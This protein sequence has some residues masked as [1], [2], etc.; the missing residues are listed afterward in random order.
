MDYTKLIT[1]E[2]PDYTYMASQWQKFRDVMEGGPAFI[3]KYLV[4]FSSRET[5]PEFAERKAI[6]Y[7]AA[8][9]KSNLFKI[10]NAMFQRFSDIKRSGGSASYQNAVTGLNFGVN[11]AGLSMNTFVA[12]YLVEEL[13]VM[14]RVG[15]YV[16]KDPLHDSTTLAD[17]KGSSPYLYPYSTE[18]I[19]SW[20]VNEKNELTAVLLVDAVDDIEL[21]SGLIMGIKEQYRYLR[22]LPDGAGVS[23]VLLDAKGVLLEETVLE[24]P[25]IPFV[26]F[27]LSQSL[28]QDVADYQVALTNLGS[29]DMSYSLKANFPFYT[30]QFNAITTMPHIKDGSDAA[31]DTAGTAAGAKENVDKQIKVG[32]TKGRRYDKGLERPGFINPSPEPLA[33]S[34][35]KQRKLE[36][37]IEVLMGINL[38]VVGTGQDVLSP[39]A[40]LSFVAMVLEAGENEIAKIWNLY[41]GS[42]KKSAIVEYPDRFYLISDEDRRK[43]ADDLSD[44]LPKMPSKTFQREATKRIADLVMGSKMSS[45]SKDKI[46]QELDSAEVIVIDPKVITEDMENGLLGAELASTARGYPDGQVEEAGKDRAKRAAAVALAQSKANQ[47][48]VADLEA[49]GARGVGDLSADPTKEAEG[50]K[51]LAQDRSQNIEGSGKKVRGGAN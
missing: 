11:G 34:M 50:E 47:A 5:A 17:T 49:P 36:K 23:A 8:Y 37:D 32:V 21:D 31:E 29:S 30:E 22:L 28:L 14:K 45:E 13:L 18:Y 44:L 35:E 33:I 39:E 10:K 16:D 27:E 15:V 20:S 6:S 38:A 24:I 7:C 9:V 48:G 40:G 12:K 41:N 51:E 19:K 25:R 43:E 2:H 3:E 1:I 26:F 4:Q 46:L 42:K